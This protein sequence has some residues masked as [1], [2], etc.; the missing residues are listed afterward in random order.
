MGQKI[1][2]LMNGFRLAFDNPLPSLN[3]KDLLFGIVIA[4]IIRLV[5]YLKGKNAKNIE[6]DRVWLCPLGQQ[7]GYSP[8][9]RP[10][11]IPK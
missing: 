5:V 3:P 7:G 4:V 10:P 2:N 9:S 11:R 8:F 1:L 6:K